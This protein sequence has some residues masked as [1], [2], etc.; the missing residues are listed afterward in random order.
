MPPAKWW[1]KSDWWTA[2]GTVAL[3]L[4]AVGSFILLWKQL[5]DT[6]EALEVDQRPWVTIAPD[7]PKEKISQDVIAEKVVLY[8]NERIQVPIKLENTGKTPALRVLYTVNIEIVDRDKAPQLENPPNPWKVIGDTLFPNA[9][10]TDFAYR[11]NPKKP[12]E[13]VFNDL[14]LP[15]NQA[16]DKGDSYLAVYGEI[17]YWD[18]FGVEHWTHFCAPVAFSHTTQT[19]NWRSCTQYNSA[20]T[21]K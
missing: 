1:G 6:R 8:P 14:T 21:N 18:G 5:N 12:G 4:F 11:L 3:A 17:S 7:W 16:L 9:P 13:R 10:Q 2:I 19:F 15:E 20:D